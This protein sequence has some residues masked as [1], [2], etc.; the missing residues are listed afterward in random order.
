MAIC[1][2]CGHTVDEQTAPRWQYQDVM[3]YFCAPGCEQ[4]VRSEPEKW[5]GIAKSG[6]Q[7]EGHEHS[8][9]H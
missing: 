8:H 1:L 9:R 3:F 4:Q 7:G 6:V 5:L 2:P